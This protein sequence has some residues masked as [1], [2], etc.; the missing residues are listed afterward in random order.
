MDI[1]GEI[2]RLLDMVQKEKTPLEL[3]VDVYENKGY[4]ALGIDLVPLNSVFFTCGVAEFIYSYASYLSGSKE[5]IPYDSGTFEY[6][7]REILIGIRRKPKLSWID[8]YESAGELYE[9]I[10][11]NQIGN[12]D[13]GF[14]FAASGGV[15]RVELVAISKENPTHFKVLILGPIAAIGILIA[16]YGGVQLFE[17]VNAPQCRQQ[18]IDYAAQSRAQVMASAKQQGQL[19]SMHNK[20]LEKIDDT[21]A[22]GIAAC[23]SSFK[24][25]G[26][27]YQGNGY[28]LKV[29]A[30][31]MH[32]RNTG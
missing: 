24:N 18:Y 26:L 21:L 16:L 7:E 22:A 11:K 8:L 13:G 1:Y 20:S 5:S 4:A 10:F 15:L 31:G 23:G 9:G 2:Q 6:F 14:W 27:E 30:G 32:K 28:K 17:T 19:T 25:L 29:D 12:R 3:S